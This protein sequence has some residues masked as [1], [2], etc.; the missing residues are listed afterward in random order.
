MRDCVATDRAPMASSV[1]NSDDDE[2]ADELLQL[3]RGED[4]PPIVHAALSWKSD[5]D[6]LDVALSVLQR[7][8]PR[9]RQIATL[10]L[11]SLL[12]NIVGSPREPR[13]R[14]LRTGSSSLAPM[15]SLGGRAVLLAVGFRESADDDVLELPPSAPVEPLERACAA[16]EASYRQAPTN[17]AIGQAP[18]ACTAS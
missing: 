8:A 17:E 3:V 14:R 10:L 7:V 5:A 12:M 9:A 4:G 1:W 16:L 2:L 6:P 13:Y 15:L 11:L 18:M